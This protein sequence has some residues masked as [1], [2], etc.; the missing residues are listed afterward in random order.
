M[1]GDLIQARRQLL[2]AFASDTAA[3]GTSSD[4]PS[5]G[6]CAAVSVVL[7]E[8]F[9]GE[10]MSATVEGQSHWYNRIPWQGGVLEVDLTGDQF[11]L[12]AIQVSTDGAL[13]PESRVRHTY[14]VNDDTNQ[15]AKLLASRAGMSL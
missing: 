13:Y 2:A 1:L 9:G 8:H 11:G 15:R 12:Y 7:K 14:E 3:P 5:A 6:H 10:H 4:I